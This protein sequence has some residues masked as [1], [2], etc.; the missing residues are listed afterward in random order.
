[1]CGIGV[2]V[3]CV[4]NCTEKQGR[5]ACSLAAAIRPRGECL[6]KPVGS[7]GWW[8]RERERVR[9]MDTHTHTRTQT[10]IH[11]HTHRYTLT[12]THS[13]TLTHTHTHSHI[14]T[15]SSCPH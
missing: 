15:P 13:H 3:C 6:S 5:E 12:H 14:H 9:E 10:Q 7:R 1:M 4:G 2:M 8:H 11:T